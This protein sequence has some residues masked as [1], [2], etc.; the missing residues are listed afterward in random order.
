MR[1]LLNFSFLCHGSIRLLS[2]ISPVKIYA[3]EIFNSNS[4]LLYSSLSCF[5]RSFPNKP[6]S[7]SLPLLV[8]FS[9]DPINKHNS[10]IHSPP[11]QQTTAQSMEL[12]FAIF[13]TNTTRCQTQQNKEEDEIIKN[14]D[15]LLRI[16]YGL[17]YY[18][19]LCGKNSNAN[20]EAIFIEYN[21]VAM[22]I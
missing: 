20:S 3:D 9:K 22:H 6:I 5:E 10:T 17:R 13:K 11:S 1:N 19:L 8:S 14:C 15:H 4:L 7:P 16:A 18:Q 21:F 12:D 2:T